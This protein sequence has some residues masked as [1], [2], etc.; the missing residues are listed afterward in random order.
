MSRCPRGVGEGE[1]DN[2]QAT[3]LVKMRDNKISR[4]DLCF[5][6]APEECKRTGEIP[7]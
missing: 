5:I 6:S 3:L 1:R 7:T 4:M 2:L